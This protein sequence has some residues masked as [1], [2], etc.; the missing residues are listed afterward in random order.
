MREGSELGSM[1]LAADYS[2]GAVH[3]VGFAL[4][5]AVAAV[6]AFVAASK[7]ISDKAKDI[8]IACVALFQLDFEVFWRR[9]TRSFR[10][11]PIIRATSPAF[12]CRSR[13]CAAAKR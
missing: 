8:T 11:G 2:Y 7:R 13:S 12:F 10:C 3:L 6:L 4:V 9:A 5:L 1:I